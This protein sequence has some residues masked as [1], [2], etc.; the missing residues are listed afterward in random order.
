VLF[1]GEDF[2]SET[3]SKRCIACAEEI[4][5]QAVLCKHCKTRQDDPSYL[6]LSTNE[7]RPEAT[8]PT[9]PERDSTGFPAA[10][11]EK[12]TS[13]EQ[14]VKFKFFAAAA[15][16]LIALVILVNI[17]R[18]GELI[19]FQDDK[20]ESQAA[21]DESKSAL[22]H[23]TDS[24][25]K[26]NA[27]FGQGTWFRGVDP[28]YG[29]AVGAVLDKGEDGGCAIWFYENPSEA[30]LDLENGY[31]NLFSD[32][33]EWFGLEQGGANIIIVA[34]SFAHPCYTGALDALG[35]AR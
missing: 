13:E 16:A 20:N 1:K 6:T 35:L 27:H 18:P 26:L 14:R 23:L 31:V 33:F 32:S 34:E 2:M 24:L 15:T 3:G 30:R 17:V 7:G 28:E 25:R 4:Q 8:Q 10:I 29:Y 19:F 12:A 21:E 11:V 22:W 5:A 9:K